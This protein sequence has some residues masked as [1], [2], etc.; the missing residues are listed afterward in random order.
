MY[1]VNLLPDE[2]TR[3]SVEYRKVLLVILTGT[4]IAFTAASYYIFLLKYNQV[5]FELDRLQKKVAAI[6]PDINRLESLSGQK[7]E[8]EKAAS[9]LEGLSA[10]RVLLSPIIA[11]INCNIPMDIWFTGLQFC[12]ECSGYPSPEQTDPQQGK[13]TAGGEGKK[14]SEVNMSVPNAVLIQGE[15]RSFLP[16]GVLVSRLYKLNYFKDVQINDVH[17]NREK[18]TFAFSLTARLNRGEN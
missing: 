3:P 2:L 15:S 6:E 18:E 16:V 5:K 17:H 14:I 10:K 7:S 13:E 1:K 8:L 12:Y 4:F 11:E 9:D